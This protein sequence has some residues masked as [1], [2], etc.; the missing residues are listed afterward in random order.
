MIIK[1]IAANDHSLLSDYKNLLEFTFPFC[2]DKKR[3]KV[4]FI[5]FYMDI[6]VYYSSCSSSI[7]GLKCFLLLT[8][9]VCYTAITAYYCFTFGPYYMNI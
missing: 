9:I 7:I 2:V 1:I 5:V 8:F 4:S 3:I 6:K